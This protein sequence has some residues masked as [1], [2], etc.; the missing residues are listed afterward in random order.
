[1]NQKNRSSKVVIEE[2]LE[3]F[4]WKAHDVKLREDGQW[5]YTLLADLEDK[6]ETKIYVKFE[7]N[8]K[9][10]YFS[11]KLE[12][13]Q[14]IV[15]NDLYKKML[16]FNYSST[17]TKIGM[18]PSGNVYMMIELPLPEIDYS[19]FVSALRRLVNDYNLYLKEFTLTPN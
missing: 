10:I 12:L 6:G 9:W 13:D 2:F 1:M 18:A 5:M 7:E 11:S 15:N 8:G 4:Q 17:L 14:S 19:E 3:K 16:S